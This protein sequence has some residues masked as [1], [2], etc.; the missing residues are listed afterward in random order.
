M[1]DVLMY[2]D[3]LRSH[4]GIEAFRARHRTDAPW[5]YL[6]PADIGESTVKE[7]QVDR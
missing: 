3:T 4:Q 1:T 5:L 2:A 6:N 7:K